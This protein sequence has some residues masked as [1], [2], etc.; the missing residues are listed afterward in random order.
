MDRCT[1]RHARAVR[2]HVRQRRPG[3]AAPTAAH[4]GEH[5][6]ARRS[7]RL[8]RL[9]RV[10][11]RRDASWSM[12]DPDGINGAQI[13]KSSFAFGS[14]GRLYSLVESIHK[15]L[16]N[17][18]TVLMGVYESRSGHVAGPWTRIADL[19]AARELA[20]LRVGLRC[21][22]TRRGSRLGTTRRSAW[23]RT[24]RTGCSWAWRRSTRP[25]T[26]V[27]RGPRS[28]PTGTSGSR[29][30]RTTWTIARRPR[31]PTSTASR[32]AR[33]SCGWPTTAAST[34]AASPRPR[35]GINN[36]ADLRMLQYYYGGTGKVPGGTAY[37]G[38]LQDNGGSLLLPGRRHDGLAVRR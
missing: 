22:D 35:S 20:G 34:A 38:G 10:D 9:L 27:T 33:A 26:R 8:Q 14:D 2:L 23:R 25:A 24:T 30:G 29:A 3:R 11:R 21:P 12:V 7:D 4:G 13:G 17:P 5:R 31:T 36:N 19:E 1:A 16:F 18:E 28:G 6:L 15:Y 37:W 32:S